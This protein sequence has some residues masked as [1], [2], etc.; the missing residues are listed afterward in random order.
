MFEYRIKIKTSAEV[1]GHFP[2]VLYYGPSWKSWITIPKA[3][4]SPPGQIQI[5]APLPLPEYK[6]ENFNFPKFFQWWYLKLY[7][8]HGKFKRTIH[9]T[10][11]GCLC[12]LECW[13]WCQCC[14]YTGAD[15]DTDAGADVDADPDAPLWTTGGLQPPETQL[16]PLDCWRQTT[17]EAVG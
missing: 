3:I 2:S 10:V 13:L 17:A 9:D 6:S 1:G 12:W 5:G 7:C 16:R 11:A 8:N 4:L 15:A 14:C